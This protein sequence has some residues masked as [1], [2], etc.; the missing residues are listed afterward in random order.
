[1]TQYKQPPLM[2]ASQPAACGVRRVAP[3][4]AALV[5][6]RADLSDSKASPPTREFLAQMI[7]E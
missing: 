2:Q 1:M 3:D 7:G 6:V 5:V 4:R